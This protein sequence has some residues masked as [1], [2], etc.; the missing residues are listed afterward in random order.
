M[1][2]ASTVSR[3]THLTLRVRYSEVDKMG[4]VYN[5]R[6]LEWFECGRTRHL[7][8]L[9]FP[10]TEIEDQGVCLPIVEPHIEFLGRADYDDSLDLVTSM[11]RVGKARVRFDN[12]IVQTEDGTG[13]ARGYTVHGS[14]DPA[15]R[16]IRPPSWLIEFLDEV[17][18]SE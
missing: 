3:Q 9:G 18:K 15:G 7:R 4:T 12:E 10:Y 13:V 11:K 5:S 8:D 14:T 17:C 6:I 16:P 1:Q 2:T